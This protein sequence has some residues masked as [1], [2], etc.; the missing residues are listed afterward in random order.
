MSDIRTSSYT[1]GVVH[2]HSGYAKG[3]IGKSFVGE[4][5][6]EK[7]NVESKIA[8]LKLKEQELYKK[9]G[10]T[11]YDDF[12]REVRNLFN[13]DDRDAIERFE[14]NRLNNSLQ[15]FAS[16]N[17]EL[18][19]QEV[20][21]TI[22]TSKIKSPEFRADLGNQKIVFPF[23][24]FAVTGDEGMK[25]FLNRFLKSKNRLIESSFNTKRMNEMLQHLMDDGAIQIKIANSDAHGEKRWSVYHRSRIPNYPWGITK[26]DI[27]DAES[28]KKVK[29][30]LLRAIERIKSFIFYELGAGATPQLHQ[31]MEAVWKRN[32]G[33]KWS[34][35]AKFFAG[36]TKGNFISVVQGA[37]GE[38][39]TAVIFEYLRNQKSVSPAMSQILGNVYTKGEQGKT[40]VEI[41]EGLGIQVKNVT[42]LESNEKA[43]LLRD[44][45]TNIHPSKFAQYMEGETSVHLLDFLANYYFN[46]SYQSAME[47]RMNQV[48]YGLS[49]WLI[50]I[51]NMAMADSAVKDTVSFYMIGGKYL[52]P[53]SVIIEA[54]KEL[55]LANS[56]EI[57]SA[58]QGRSDIE[59]ARHTTKP[60]K[61]GE[62]KHLFELY[63]LK[64]SGTWQPTDENE[65]EYRNLVEKA[66]SIRTHFNLLNEIQ[67]YA[68][69][70]I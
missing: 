64:E 57:T 25:K 12:I 26:N 15:H 59:Y 53:C 23:K 44:L 36:T 69:W 43:S 55:K 18:L 19:D 35:P 13:S 45:K 7:G 30:D 41:F 49:N 24:I 34:D 54:G 9:F 33:A 28:N 1:T 50:E 8:Q 40:D 2:T 17:S 10:K 68:L 20:E 31:A 63:W 38:F 70:E 5:Y 22:N 37:L 65:K 60:G 14:A 67:R 32:F 29:Q 62:Q 47:A 11:N 21:I 61:N 39:Q 4:L 58:Y 52:V 16:A 48:R 42:V 27:E 51:M 3:N 6:R 46:T 56:I 66:I